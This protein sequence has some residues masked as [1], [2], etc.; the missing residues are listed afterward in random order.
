MDYKESKLQI[1]LA[2]VLS[3]V[4]TTLFWM[5]GTVLGGIVFGIVPATV[6]AFHLI[7]KMRI[8]LQRAQMKMFRDWW[9]AYRVNFKQYWRASFISSFIAFIL[10][11]NYLFLNMQTSYIT[12]VAFYVTI[13]F[14]VVGFFVLM[15]FCFLSARYPEKKT[16]ERVRNAVAYP[17]SFM[18]EMIIITVLS[19]A[20][21]LAIWAVTPGLVI[22]TGAGTWLFAW[23]WVFGKIHDTNGRY[24]L[25]Q[26]WYRPE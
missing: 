9:Q 16:H 4:I 14:F 20:A 11:V 5:A 22:F 18:L 17:L 26:Y 3:I 21:M 1:G 12:Y 2:W 23:Q 15:W 10:V 24:R 19:I 25:K 13:L 8:D 7:I 6:T